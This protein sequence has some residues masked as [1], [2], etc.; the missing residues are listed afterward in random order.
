MKTQ[1]RLQL[2]L[3][4]ALILGA[5][6]VF[7]FP[8][9]WLTLGSFKPRSELLVVSLPTQPTLENYSNVLKEFPVGTYLRNSLLVALS[10]TSITLAAGS[11]AAYGFTRYRFRGRQS[12]LISTLLMRILPAVAVGIPLYLLFSRLRLTNTYYGLILAHVAGQLP[13]VIWILQGFFQDLP[14]ELMDAGL[15][16]GCNRLS[17]L[18]HVVLPLA[19]PGLAVAAIFSFLISWNDFGLAVMMVQK[20][21]VLTMPVGMSHMSLRFGIR[22]DSLSAS[23]VMYIVPTIIMALI[24]QRYVVRG[25]TMGAIKG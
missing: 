23:A 17:V 7:L 13:L 15:V 24:L 5:V 4:Y 22:W 1:R 20:P 9:I 8:I 16:D 11:L 10:S 21:G 6:V 19:A 14:P 3:S 25:L 18:Y 12:L 2:V